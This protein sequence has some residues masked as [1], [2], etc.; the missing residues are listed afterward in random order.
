MK[1]SIDAKS[2][3]PTQVE[4]NAGSFKFII[5]EPKQLGGTNEGPNPVEYVLAALSGCLNVV[6]HLVAQ[7][8][9]IKINNLDIAIS[10]ELDPG[11]FT[12]QS[13]EKRAGFESINVEL[14]LDSDANEETTAKWIKAV[15]DRCPVSDNLSHETLINI[16]VK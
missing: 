7:E 2:T 15:E 5:D 10:G 9:G 4:V 11:R 6:G 13:Y 12:G 14:N 16:V 8:M 3:N 1:V